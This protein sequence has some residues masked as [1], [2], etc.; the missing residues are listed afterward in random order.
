M[1]LNLNIVGNRNKFFILSAALLLATLLFSLFGGVKLDI[2][3]K[4]GTMITYSYTGKIDQ[5]VL[6]S[7]VEEQLGL[8]ANLTEKVDPASGLNMLEISF[9]DSAGLTIERQ[10]ALTQA[11]QKEFP[12]N[13]LN[14]EESNDVNPSMGQE[15]FIKCLVAVGVAAILMIIYIAI[16][17]RRIGGWSAGVTSVIALFHDVVMVY[18]VFLFFRIPLN[19]NFVAAALTILGYSIND[20]IVI[21]DRIRENKKLMGDKVPFA[22]LVNT[23]INQSFAR[24]LNTTICTLMSMAVVCIVAF[25]FDVD[26][27]ITFAFPMIIGMIS[28]VYSSV[29]LSGPMWVVWNEWKAKRASNSQGH[30]KK[31]K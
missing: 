9:A 17:F 7:V 30:K 6:D 31:K 12:D 27:I 16:R 28:G 29:C 3:F 25:I 13:E 4:G 2:Q 26:S 11:L 21:Y 20:T 14:L 18:A 22:E 23:S 24:S 15:F 1:K 8:E 10:T 19:A 5:D